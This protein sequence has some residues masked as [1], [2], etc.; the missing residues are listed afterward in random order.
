MISVAETAASDNSNSKM[1]FYS[2]AKVH[3]AVNS[4]TL[5]LSVANAIALQ[6]SCASSRN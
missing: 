6:F 5:A 1:T 4:V 2:F 3:S